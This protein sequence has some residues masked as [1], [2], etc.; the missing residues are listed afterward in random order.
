MIAPESIVHLV[1]QIQVLKEQLE[2]SQ[3]L[4]R[5]LQAIPR[6]CART[7]LLHRARNVQGPAASPSSTSRWKGRGLSAGEPPNMSAFGGISVARARVG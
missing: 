1:G 5:E 3:K 2:K 4:V 7:V 6:A